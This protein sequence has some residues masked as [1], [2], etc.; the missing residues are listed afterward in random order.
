MKLRPLLVLALVALPALV[1]ACSGGTTSRALD[2]SRGEMA[3]TLDAMDARVQA[4]ADAADG[5]RTAETG[6]GNGAAPLA[7]RLQAEVDLLRPACAQLR[8]TLQSIALFPQA[9]SSLQVSRLRSDAGS[10]AVEAVSLDERS[11]AL[12][13]IAVDTRAAGLP[14]A[15]EIDAAATAFH[16]DARRVQA[17]A[18]TLAARADRL[19]E[20]LG[21]QP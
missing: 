18:D 4:L 17:T 13:A 3:T 7:D 1:V 8:G 12:A 21:L 11:A 6:G 15:D 9:N 2:I 14:Q 16:E 5:V 20:S 19:A 10:L